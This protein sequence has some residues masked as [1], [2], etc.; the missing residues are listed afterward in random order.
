MGE[1]AFAKSALASGHEIWD[2][3]VG[4]DRSLVRGIIRGKR[5]GMVEY[6]RW[7]RAAFLERDLANLNCER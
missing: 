2:K 1:R 3:R 6:A 5:V 7:E 4:N